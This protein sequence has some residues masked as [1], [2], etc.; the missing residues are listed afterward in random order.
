MPKYRFKCE[1]CSFVWEE[2]QSIEEE[3]FLCSE[4]DS[5]DIKKLPAGIF[6]AKRPPKSSK[7]E[8]GEATKEHI[9]KNREILK[10]IKREMDKKEIN[11]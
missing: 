2:W 3:T 11:I 4:C 5:N 10:Q 6:V 7:K 8:T 9:E 1:N